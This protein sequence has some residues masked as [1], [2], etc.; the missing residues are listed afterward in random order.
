MKDSETYLYADDTKIFRGIY[1]LEDCEKLQDDLDRA[2]DWTTESLMKFHP[3]KCK[4][5][6][7]GKDDIN[8]YYYTMGND[9]VQ[10]E[11][12][13]KEKDIGIVI[14]NSL[15]F[16]HH[17]TQK[18]NK[19]NSVLYIIRHTFEQLD[20]ESFNLLY[21]GLV[22][23]QIEYA[24]QVWNPYLKKHITQIENVQRRATKQVPGLSEL[25]YSERLKRLKL[26]TLTYRRHRGDMIEMYKILTNKYDPEVCNDF[27]AL[28]NVDS[29]RGHKYKI[30]KERPRLNIRKNSFKFRCADSWNRLTDYVVNAP[31]V[32]AFE[33][34]LDQYY[35]DHPLVYDY[36]APVDYIPNRRMRT[37]EI[38]DDSDL[39]LVV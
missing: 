25:S 30:Y 31:T 38:W 23:P 35:K 12:S 21:K 2:H 24:N 36:N 16:E 9:K 17:I 5:M 1:T 13:E 7:I 14:D 26:P 33:K 20:M 4:S 15:S 6:R 3:Q 29:T 22:R 19:A 27:I 11:K 34:R 37:V 10:L 18:V 39:T 8:E 28:S 32:C